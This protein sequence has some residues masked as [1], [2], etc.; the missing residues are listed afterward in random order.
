MF[1]QVRGRKRRT[2]V[3]GAGRPR[4]IFARLGA[5]ATGEENRE[6]RI[7]FDLAN[8]PFQKTTV[9]IGQELGLIDEEDELRRINRTLRLALGLC[10]IEELEAL[11]ADGW[12]QVGIEG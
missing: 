1:D 10:G 7:G 4:S 11:V 9:G 3:R 8:A 12:R 5:G 6:P 2:G